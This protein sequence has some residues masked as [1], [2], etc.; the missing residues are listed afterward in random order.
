M[1]YI[2]LLVYSAFGIYSGPDTFTISEF[3]SK[4]SC[5]LALKEAKKFYRTVNDKS[6]CISVE[7]ELNKEKLKKELDDDDDDVDSDNA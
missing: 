4:A 6:K 3:Q 1:S 7:K 2:L 5:E